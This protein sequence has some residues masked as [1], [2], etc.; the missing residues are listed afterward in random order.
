MIIDYAWHKPTIKQLKDNKVDIVGRYI[1]QDNTGKNLTIPEVKELGNNGI[2]IVTVFEYGA[3]QATGGSK[4]GDID[5]K[6]AVDQT[7]ALGQPYGTPIFFSLDFDVP[8]YAPN[9][10]NPRSK[11]GPIADY[12]EAI[13]NHVALS[14]IG[15]Y[16]DYY[17]LKRLSA[18]NL[19]RWRWQTLAWSGGQVLDHYDLYQNGKKFLGLADVDTHEP[20]QDYIGQWTST[21]VKPPKAVPE[22]EVVLETENG[23]KR[24][25]LPQEHPIKLENGD[26]LVFVRLVT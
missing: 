20:G 16:G 11:L 7:H 19:I 2:E 18:A 1:G 15:G 12:F 26:T 13:Q 4:Q 6:L 10:D 21:L 25:F 23:H 9:S 24:Y 22:A 14:W 5:G 17:A 3:A 8:D